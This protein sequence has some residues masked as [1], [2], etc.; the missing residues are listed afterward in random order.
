MP[1][2]HYLQ[3]S[4]PIRLQQKEKMS[5]FAKKNNVCDTTQKAADADFHKVT[6]EEQ[7]V[8]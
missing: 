6:K 5:I 8:I 3:F 4:F 2:D 1:H 7:Q